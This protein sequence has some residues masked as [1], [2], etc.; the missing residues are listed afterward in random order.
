MTK[1]QKNSKTTIKKHQQGDTSNFSWLVTIGSVI[2]VGV[3]LVASVLTLLPRIT[4]DVSPI[5]PVHPYKIAL[6][7]TNREPILLSS[8]VTKYGSFRFYDGKQNS[9]S[10][11][12]KRVTAN[13]HGCSAHW[14]NR[15][16]H[17]SRAR[18][19]SLATMMR[20]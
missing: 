7:I 9:G 5:D 1:S 2:V 10:L 14:S 16:N 4:V 8:S 12:E 6:T 11:R 17:F 18:P 20:P 15:A 13:S 19:I 3:G